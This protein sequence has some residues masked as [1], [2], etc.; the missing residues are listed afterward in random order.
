MPI[1]STDILKADA[2]ILGVLY[3]SIA[4]GSF[5]GTLVLARSGKKTFHGLWLLILATLLPVVLILFSQFPGF[6]VSL[7]LLVLIGAI[8]VC[9]QTITLTRIQTLVPDSLQGT[10]ISLYNLEAGALAF[11]TLLMGFIV[12][13]SGIQTAFVIMNIPLLLIALVALVVPSPIKKMR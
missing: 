11:G 3:G 4:V 6:Y 12:E 13:F 7:C 9:F 5:I 8:Q 2:G 1:W 10:V